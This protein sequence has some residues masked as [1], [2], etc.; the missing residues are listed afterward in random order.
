MF[1]KNYGRLGASGVGCLPMHAGLMGLVKTLPRLHP[2]CANQ[3]SQIL[4]ED[5]VEFCFLNLQ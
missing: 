2:A 4:F 5:A 1:V 3:N